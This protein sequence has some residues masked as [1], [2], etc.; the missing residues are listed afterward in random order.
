MATLDVRPARDLL[1]RDI[2][3]MHL[4]MVRRHGPGHDDS[5]APTG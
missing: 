2:L 1:D 3:P 4:V 5:P